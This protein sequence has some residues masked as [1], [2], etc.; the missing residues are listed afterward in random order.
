MNS[1]RTALTITILA[2]LI[3]VAATWRMSWADA[4]TFTERQLNFSSIGIA[5]GGV[6]VEHL[7]A[8]TLLAMA[9]GIT[10]LAGAIVWIAVKD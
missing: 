4:A 2:A 10:L 6:A 5:A 8:A 3:A 9:A 1:K 7:S